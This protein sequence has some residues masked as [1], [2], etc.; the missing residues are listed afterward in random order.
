M[1]SVKSVAFN[2]SLEEVACLELAVDKVL[3]MADRAKVETSRDFWLV[4]L[5]NCH[6]RFPLNLMDLLTGE[7]ADFARDVFGIRNYFDV[8]AGQW[9]SEWRPDC[10]RPP[11]QPKPQPVKFSDITQEWCQ[12]SAGFD[13]KATLDGD[14]TAAELRAIAQRME[15]NP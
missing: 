15:E 13:G 1:D 9:L 7:D 5:G 12:Y 6:A 3:P 14:Y 4:L 2:A 11:A 8:K 10:M